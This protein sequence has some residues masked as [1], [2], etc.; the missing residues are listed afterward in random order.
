MNEKKET[1]Y[2]EKNIS[3]GQYGVPLLILGVI[4]LA[5]CVPLIIF[6]CGAFRAR[7]CR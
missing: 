5:A 7:F 3:G 1:I 6:G 2:E 4:L